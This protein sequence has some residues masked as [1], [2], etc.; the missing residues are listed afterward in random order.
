MKW[1]EDGSGRRPLTYSSYILFRDVN[2]L[3]SRYFDASGL[4]PKSKKKIPPQMEIIPSPAF[5]P[6]DA[7]SGAPAPGGCPRMDG[8]ARTLRRP[9]LKPP[10]PGGL[11]RAADCETLANDPP[12]HKLRIARARGRALLRCPPY[13]ARTV[14]RSEPP[15]WA[16]A[17]AMRTR[18]RPPYSSLKS[19]A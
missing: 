4:P 10:G 2:H 14:H 18:A 7:P 5:L 13:R 19:G 16:C 1:P 12:R 6:I 3:S 11:C 8:R 17:S 9:L 15:V